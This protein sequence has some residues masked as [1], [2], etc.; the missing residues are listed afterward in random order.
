MKGELVTS[1]K[2]EVTVSKLTE[3]SVDININLWILNPGR[4]DYIISKLIR[5]AKEFLDRVK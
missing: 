2:P 5:D 4:R 1:K 3:D